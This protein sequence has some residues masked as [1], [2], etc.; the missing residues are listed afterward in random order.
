MQEEVPEANEIEISLLGGGGGTGECIVVHAGNNEWVVVDSFLSKKSRKPA[1]L[2]YLSRMGIPSTAVKL[3]VASHWHNDHIKGISNLIS[4]ATEAKFAIS[5]ALKSSEF[6]TLLEIDHNAHTRQRSISELRLALQTLKERGTPITTASQDKDIWCN[7]DETCLVQALSPSDFAEG[8]AREE[9]AQIVQGFDAAN[10]RIL[11]IN[12]NHNSIVIRIK[13][14]DK[15]ILLGSDLE[16]SSEIGMGWSAILTAIHRP[17]RSASTFKVAHHGSETSYTPKIWEE[18]LISN[19]VALIT[20]FK[21]GKT[22]LPTLEYS[23]KILA[24][25]PHAYITSDPNVKFKPK[26]RDSKVAKTIKQLGYSPIE[27]SYPDGHIRLRSKID[28]SSW[29]IE[30]F[31]SALALKNCQWS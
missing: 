28:E 10:R 18:L 17:R 23:N 30:L 8:F 31:G 19:P 15:D 5:S 6:G 11:N 14:G 3:V 29:Q 26:K 7:S 27:L 13:A 12:P 20:P 16:E 22:K 24:H 2:E 9:I 21:G 25:T 4:E 1:S